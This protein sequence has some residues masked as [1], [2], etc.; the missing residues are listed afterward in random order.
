MKKYH[1]YYHKNR[2]FF[3]E[4]SPFAKK[5][6]PKNRHHLINFLVKSRHLV[7]KFKKICRQGW[8]KSRQFG[9]LSPFLVT[10]VLRFVTALF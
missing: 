7:N 6:L 8:T 5:G 1:S 9:D 10:L 2:H 4:K 3:R